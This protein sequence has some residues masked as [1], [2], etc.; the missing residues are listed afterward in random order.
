MARAQD[1]AGR[2]AGEFV[3]MVEVGGK[4]VTIRTGWAA[5]DRPLMGAGVGHGVG[6]DAGAARRN[7]G[8]GPHLRTWSG[9]YRRLLNRHGAVLCGTAPQDLGSRGALAQCQAAASPGRRR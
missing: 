3:G 2:N 5:F 1:A 6:A 7:V 9:A 4:G 8:G